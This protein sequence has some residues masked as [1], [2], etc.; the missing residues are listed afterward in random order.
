MKKEM[1][2]DAD[3]ELHLTM[4]QLMLKSC[5]RQPFFL[6]SFVAYERIVC[7]APQDFILTIPATFPEDVP[8]SIALTSDEYDPWTETSHKFRFYE[9]PVIV[10]CDP[11][12]VEV[13]TISEVLVWADENSEFFEPVPA[14]RPTDNDQTSTLPLSSF[15]G[16]TCQFGRFGETQAIFIN[17]TVIKCVTPSIEDEPDSIYREVV[18]LTVA[19][20]GVDHDESS[21]TIEFTFVGTGTYLVFWPFIIGAL[22]IGLLIVA[23]VLCCTTIFQK[24]S[25]DDMLAGKRPV[26]GN[27]GLPHT[28]NLGGGVMVPRGRA[29][30]NAERSSVDMLERVSGQ[31]FY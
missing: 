25:M 18:K 19:M 30:W 23:L 31:Q 2:P 5:V 10:K 14:S 22:L 16:I 29:D 3:L 7:K 1:L 28:F 21:S 12:E 13:G 8:I 27:E 17:E 9:Q 11:C 20:N 26:G 15:A 6:N 24:M 4:P